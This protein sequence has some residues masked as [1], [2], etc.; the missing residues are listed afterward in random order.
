[1][2]EG[3]MGQDV[4]SVNDGTSGKD[5]W[6]IRA[7]T[8]VCTNALMKRF[9]FANICTVHKETF[10]IHFYGRQKAKTER[11]KEGKKITEPNNY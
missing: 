1:M 6:S 3:T 10:V 8:L 4:G 7:W 5:M 2:G 11:K 9:N